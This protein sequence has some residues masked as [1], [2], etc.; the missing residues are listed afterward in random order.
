MIQEGR[1]GRFGRKSARLL[2]AMTAGA[3]L[4]ALAAC[5]SSITQRNAP[6]PVELYGGALQPLAEP[7]LLR[8]R[9]LG[10]AQLSASMQAS[11]EVS[12]YNFTWSSSLSGRA[13]IESAGEGLLR[14]QVDFT[15][16]SYELH[17]ELDVRPF[18]VK[19]LMTDLG[20]IREA[21][22]SFSTSEP[23]SETQRRRVIAIVTELFPI[24]LWPERPIAPGEA[25][26]AV[27]FRTGRED[28]VTGETGQI[29]LRI[30]GSTTYDGRPAYLIGFT[31]RATSLSNNSA[32]SGYYVVDAQSGF[33]LEHRYTGR[34]KDYY[35]QFV[36]YRDYD[37]EAHLR[38]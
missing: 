21:L 24:I 23:P 8:Y 1:H 34:D 7:V 9:P 6:A 17:E 20:E 4:L 22:W 36:V 11:A 18:S 15:V 14:I 38:P 12:S 2:A 28:M 16:G 27:N 30:D 25:F 13:R 32:I 29:D 33:V 26:S 19:L 35:Q 10:A 3:A 5:Q 31:G 37:V